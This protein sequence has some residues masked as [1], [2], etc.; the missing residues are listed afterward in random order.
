MIDIGILIFDDVEE[1]DFVGPWEVW[2]MV[3]MVSRFRGEA[4]PFRVRLISSDG[5]QIR[6]AKGMRVLADAA[7]AQVEQ[8][9]IICVPGG[10]GARALLD[11]ADVLD[12]VRSISKH[13]KWV[14]SVCTGAFVL[15]KAGLTQGKRLATYIGQHLRN[16]SNWVCPELWFPM[17]DMS[18]METY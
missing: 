1:L 18:A 12:W 6:A 16:L 17:S 13:A 9:D 3:N 8:L 11:Q 10:Q 14:T 4:D 5:Q 7:I 2:N 15:S